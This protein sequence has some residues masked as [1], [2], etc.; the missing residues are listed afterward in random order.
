M[1]IYKNIY[2]RNTHTYK[3]PPETI[4]YKTLNIF[5]PP[6]IPS[7]LLP[8]NPHPPALQEAT[9]LTS[10]TIGLLCLLLYFIDVEVNSLAFK[11]ICYLVSSFFGCSKSAEVTG[12]G[13]KP[14]PQQ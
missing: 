13:I 7:Y 9:S 5:T 8:V 4:T 2:N 6:K 3:P 1:C 10:I 11:T 12:S 14:V